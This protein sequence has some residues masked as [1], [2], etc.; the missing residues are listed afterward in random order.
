MTHE[1]V[2]ILLKDVAQQR[3]DTELTVYNRRVEINIPEFV[4]DRYQGETDSTVAN[5][6]ALILDD[7]ILLV[8]AVKVGVT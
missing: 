2:P 4:P 1:D 6:K 8:E 7:R 3:H 5:W